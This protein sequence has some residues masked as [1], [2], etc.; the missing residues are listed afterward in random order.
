MKKLR[1]VLL[2]GDGLRHR[3]AAHQLVSGFDLAGVLCETKVASVRK[4]EE[5]SAE[6][7]DVTRKHLL[8]RDEVELKLLS[9]NVWLVETDVFKVPVGGSNSPEAFQWVKSHR[10]DIVILYGTNIIKPP[11][12]NFY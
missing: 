9:D 7:L 2:T 11:L 10:P 6:D 1:A 5:L 4:P 12:L 3:Y 8:E